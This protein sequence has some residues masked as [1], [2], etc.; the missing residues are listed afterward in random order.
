MNKIVFYIIFCLVVFSSF[1]GCRRGR[2][3]AEGQWRLEVEYASHS[4]LDSVW[5][6]YTYGTE[7]IGI[8][9]LVSDAR[10][11]RL[12]FARTFGR[13]TLDLCIVFDSEGNILV[14]IFPSPK[15]SVARLVMD[16]RYPRG[17]AIGML[18]DDALTTW[19]QIARD[20]TLTSEH[21]RDTLRTILNGFLDHKVGAM[22]YTHYALHSDSSMITELVQDLGRRLV[23]EER[24]LLDV[25]GILYNKVP[26]FNSSSRQK[27][28]GSQLPIEVKEK[29]VLTAL[30]V[31]KFVGKKGIGLY[32]FT[33]LSDGDSL[34]I[35]AAEQVIQKMDSLKIPLLT[36]LVE[37]DEMPKGWK[38]YTISQ[39]VKT[40][41]YFV[42]DTLSE[43]TDFA[44]QRHITHI[45]TYLLI[46]SLGV[47]LERWHEADSVWVHFDKK[48]KQ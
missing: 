23:M 42:L 15:S 25:V 47:I 13:D 7:H 44:S 24:D 34:A 5:Y 2:S 12:S 8:D 37:T 31:K 46:D 26:F 29:D 36:T 48:D 20:T 39:K 17:A 6:L 40:P 1:F 43:A 11:G 41:S 28:V 10:K 21:R 30:S 16:K 32:Q 45:P 14:P 18:Q 9:T 3:V 35:K 19:L 4:R 22:I 33:T 38:T 27:S